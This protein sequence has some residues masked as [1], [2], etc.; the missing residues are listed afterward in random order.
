ML[1][2][3]EGGWCANRTRTCDPVIT[4]GEF[5]RF[6]QSTL[7]RACTFKSTSQRVL[8]HVGPP[9]EDAIECTQVNGLKLR[10]I[11]KT[12]TEK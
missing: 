12:A 6:A 4:K 1:L 7:M 2:N 8:C 9:N 5:V 11:L 3:L 10:G